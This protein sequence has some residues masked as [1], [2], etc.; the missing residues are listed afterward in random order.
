MVYPAAYI[1]LYAKGG[2]AKLM[3]INRTETSYD[4][5][6]D[7]VIRGGAGEVMTGIVANLKRTG[8]LCA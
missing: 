4:A 1:P 2:G 8:G 3:I 7:L 5:N 6:A